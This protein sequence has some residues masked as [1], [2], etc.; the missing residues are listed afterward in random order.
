MNIEV[1]NRQ[2]S[3]DLKIAESKV[4]IVNKY[5]WQKV[6]NH[7]Y[8]YD[9]QPINIENVCV[10][11]PEQWLLKKNIYLYINRLRALKVNKRFKE[12][13]VMRESYIEKNKQVLRN[14]LKLR[15]HYKYTN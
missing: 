13:S 10:I 8:S 15:K 5:Y 9:P 2:I 7:L 3:K 11:H 12:G 4:T 14:Y 1:V 6:Y